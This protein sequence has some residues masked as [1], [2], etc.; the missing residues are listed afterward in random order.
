MDESISTFCKTLACFCKHL[1][2]SSDTL[3]ESVERRPIPL[4]SASSTFIQCL[5]R[6]VKSA[7]S[8]LNFL[9][10]M[11][12]DTVSFEELLG[13]C[14]ELYKKNQDYLIELEDRFK[15][16]GYTPEA[17]I[18]DEDE[19][20]ELKT[21]PG[22]N[23]KLFKSDELDLSAFSCEPRSIIKRLENDDLF[24]KSLSIQNMGLSDACLATLA[25]GARGDI[26]MPSLRRPINFDDAEL[27][28]AKGR[29]E[30]ATEVLDKAGGELED[31][32]KSVGGAAATLI[33]ISKDDYES[34]VPSYMKSLASWE[35]MEAAVD[36]MNSYLRGNEKP[37]DGNLFYQDDLATLNLGP[38]VRSY[39]L[40]LLRM[41]RL[42]VET[43]GGSI[44]YRVL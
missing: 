16:F 40:L 11:A 23:S 5:N 27:P 28:G 39:M 15:S 3:K 41:N 2:S 43:V 42:V 35:D 19:V 21:P 44:V 36:K 37:K 22:Y 8:D 17:E 26:D 18:D 12:F 1:Q 29:H 33:K 30:P 6:R 31:K 25:S 14:N 10:S 20:S 32:P 34:N 38:K 7:S 9:E 24:Q 4:D 13:H